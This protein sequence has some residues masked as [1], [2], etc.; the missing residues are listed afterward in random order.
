MESP[1]QQYPNRPP[2][3]VLLITPQAVLVNNV[4]NKAVLMIKEES[5]ALDKQRQFQQRLG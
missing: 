2:P 5:R 4:A 1:Q 3:E